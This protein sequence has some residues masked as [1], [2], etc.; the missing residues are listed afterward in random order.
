MIVPAYIT[1]IMLG[2][3]IVI[4]KYMNEIKSMFGE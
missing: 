1:I 2:V 4:V 3:M